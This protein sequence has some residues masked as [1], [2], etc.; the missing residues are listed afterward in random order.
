MASQLSNKS[1]SQWSHLEDHP[2]MRRT[3]KQL[4][5]QAKISLLYQDRFQGKQP[6]SLK[7]YNLP[8]RRK[9]K[10]NWEQADKIRS[11]YIPGVHGKKKLAK[12]FGVS[13]AVI[14]RILNNESWTIK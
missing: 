13:K 7:V 6:E 9:C 10:I 14:T 1:Q 8:E 2:L 5:G 12:E 11:S 3:D 4:E